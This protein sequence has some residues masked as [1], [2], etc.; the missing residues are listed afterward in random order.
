MLQHKS[1][2]Q[3]LTS[4]IATCEEI[5]CNTMGLAGPRSPA[6]GLELAIGSKLATY[7]VHRRLEARASSLACRC[8]VRE[9]SACET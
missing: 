2:P 8:P 9:L 1:Q 6:T 7:L 5:Y 4:T 3:H